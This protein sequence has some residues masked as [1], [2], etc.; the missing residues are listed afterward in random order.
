MRP[1]T[2]G[3]ISLPPLAGPPAFAAGKGI[4]IHQATHPACPGAASRDMMAG[5]NKAQLIALG[6][7]L[8]AFVVSLFFVPWSKVAKVGLP[9]L[10]GP[11][12]PLE[13]AE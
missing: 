11:H 3:T 13:R 6:I 4:L 12:A 10:F 7:G 5:V 2:P 9:E 8:A 1:L